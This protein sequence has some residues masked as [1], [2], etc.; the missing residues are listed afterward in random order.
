MNCRQE[1][2]AIMAEPIK[3]GII[4]NGLLLALFF[5]LCRPVLRL[6]DQ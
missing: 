4:M 3:A 2:V 5:G 6:W 1:R